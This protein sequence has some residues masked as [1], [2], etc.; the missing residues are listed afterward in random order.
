[1][2][3]S[4]VRRRLQ[5]QEYSH[6]DEFM[7]DVSLTF[8]NAIA[9][10]PEDNFVWKH[11]TNMKRIWEGVQRN[12]RILSR[13]LQGDSLGGGASKAQSATQRTNRSIDAHAEAPK[14]TLM[15]DSFRR[16][17][18]TSTM[19]VSEQTRERKQNIHAIGDKNGKV[20]GA[21]CSGRTAGNSTSC[22]LYTSDAADE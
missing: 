9:Y 7:R 2:D 6:V 12:T 17:R 18:P 4:E 16:H 20:R 8:D 13:A 19:R 21:D 11:A 5:T 15:F 14:R 1:M 10:N 3:L 22:L